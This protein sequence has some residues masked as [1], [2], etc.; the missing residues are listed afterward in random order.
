MQ[1]KEIEQ[2]TDEELVLLSLEKAENYL[3]LMKR[4][5]SKLIRYILRISNVTRED[6]E[7]ILQ[8][9]FISV[10]QNLNGFDNAFKFSSWIYRITHNKTISYIRKIK[11]RPKTID[12]EDKEIL[13]KLI[14]TKEMDLEI[15]NEVLK[16]KLLD[17]I[18][19]LEVKYKSVLVLRFIEGKEYSEISD[20]L[21]MPI[22]TVG[23]LI[24]RAKKLLKDKISKE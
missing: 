2:K 12:L 20:I 5:E 22:N 15:H 13:D 10:Y 4:Y 17:E 23:T 21:K 8:D 3:F 6:A 19:S 9:T 14:I 18:N 11:A 7:D 24:N 1:A 16:E